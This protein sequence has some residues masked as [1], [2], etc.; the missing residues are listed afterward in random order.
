MKSLA[1]SLIS[2]QY[3]ESN[4]NS[5]AIKFVEEPK[6]CAFYAISKENHRSKTWLLFPKTV[7]VAHY[8]E[9]IEY[10]IIKSKSGC[11]THDKLSY[12]HT[13][14]VFFWSVLYIKKLV[15]AWYIINLFTLVHLCI[16]ITLILHCSNIYKFRLPTFWVC[17][18]MHVNRFLAA[19]EFY[20]YLFIYY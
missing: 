4:S 2:S 10:H 20:M 9:H 6:K 11:L 14:G 12:I 13:L 8:T 19:S 16:V 3:G 7:T 17:M 1:E 5:P 15:Y 18:Y